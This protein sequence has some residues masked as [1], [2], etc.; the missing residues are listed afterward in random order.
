M[1]Q[2][3]REA[4]A[5]ALLVEASKHLLSS[6]YEVLF[7][8]DVM[9][10]GYGPKP[11]NG[12]ELRQRRPSGFGPTKRTRSL[13]I[14]VHPAELIGYLFVAGYGTTI[15]K[16]FEA[17]RLPNEPASVPKAITQAWNTLSNN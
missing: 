14:Y 12:I 10:T 16:H 7:S 5:E 13:S 1:D 8:Y 17:F 6:E 3:A 4:V 9:A 15:A 11:I 2:I